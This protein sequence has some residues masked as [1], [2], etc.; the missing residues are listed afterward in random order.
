MEGHWAQFKEMENIPSESFVSAESLEQLDWPW[1]VEQLRLNLRT[2]PARE[3]CEQLIWVQD[4]EAALRKMQEVA[5]AEALMTQG[6]TFPLG[7][8]PDIRPHQL[9]IGKGAILSPLELQDIASW[10]ETVEAVRK[11]LVTHRT[12]V[13]LLYRYASSAPIL[14]HLIYDIRSCIDENAEVRDE[15]SPELGQLRRTSRRINQ[16][17]HQRLDGY[18]NAKELQRPLQDKYYTIKEDRYVLPI[19]INQRMFVDGIVLGSSNSGATLFIEP[20]EIVDLN[21]THKITLLEIQ[22]EVYRILLEICENIHQDVKEIEK[23]HYFLTQIDLVG[24]RMRLSDSQSSTIPTLDPDLGV[25]LIKSR[26]PILYATKPDT[27]P[28][29]I[30]IAPPIST[31]LVSGPNAGGKTAVLKTVGLFALMVRAGLPLP[32][33]RDSNMPFFDHIFSDIGDNQSLQENRSTFSGHMLRLVEFISSRPRFSLAL[34]DEILIG[35]N[36]DEGSALAQ[37]ILENLSEAGG[38]NLATTH[39]LSLKSVATTNPYIMNAALGFHP[40]TLEPTYELTAG[41]PGSSNALVIARQLGLPEALLERARSLLGESGIDIQSL[42]QQIHAAKDEA[43]VEKTRQQHL[44]QEGEARLMEIQKRLSEVDSREREVKKKYR[45]RLERA[46]NEALNELKQQKKKWKNQE[47]PPPHQ[48]SSERKEII[49]S[50][51]RLLAES[52]LFYV[53]PSSLGE[54]KRIDWSEVKCGDLVYVPTLQGEARVLS[55]PDRRGNLTVEAKGF[56]MQVKAGD[57]YKPRVE[58]RVIRNQKPEDTRRQALSQTMTPLVSS[59]PDQ[60]GRLDLRG[61]TVEE[62]LDRVSQC[63]DQGFRESLPFL[64]LIHGL[65]KGILRNAVREHLSKAPYPLRF[66]PGRREEGGEGVTIVEFDI[67]SLPR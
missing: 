42:L 13:P 26:H 30:A 24:A 33:G 11:F 32:A 61:L 65:G 12:Q 6:H 54:V 7:N 21:N 49:E 43:I 40:H 51:D 46:F 18:L 27:V 14:S 41:V 47:H 15:A 62:A 19:K 31:L 1:I 66:R 45:D 48:T 37:A 39:F 4:R 38:L 10:M 22:K 23:G 3:G 2:Q 44:R 67:E 55:L 20:R 17:I 29:D 63:L 28:N 16:E 25:N 58:K 36:P 5:E 59:L 53:P 56:R 64:T 35:T 50:K 60:S 57:T 34:L 9:R 52:G 8:P